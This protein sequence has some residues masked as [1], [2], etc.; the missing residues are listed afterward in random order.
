MIEL[1][2]SENDV[3][4]KREKKCDAGSWTVQGKK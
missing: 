2:K 3:R 4:M 1:E